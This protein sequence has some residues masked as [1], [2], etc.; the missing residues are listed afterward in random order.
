MSGD[1]YLR[2]VTLT[3]VNLPPPGWYPDP[4]GQGGYRWW[5]GYQ[6]TWY[7]SGGPATQYAPGGPATLYAPGGPMGQW[8]PLSP[9]PPAHRIP[10][11]AA[12]WGLAGVVG[13]IVLG[14]ILQGVATAA[15]PGSD[16]AAL[17][18]GEIGL[19]AA[20]AATC[21]LVSRRYGTGRLSD[22][23]GLRFKPGDVPLGLGV[24]VILLFVAGI[25]GAL[26]A[27]TSLHGSNT[28]FLTGQRGNTTGVVVVTLVAAVGAP[29]FEELF[30]RGFLRI[31]LAA[32][33][34]TGA[35]WVQA[36][37]FG[38]AHY[39]LTLGWQSISVIVA[40]GAL[41]VVLGFLAQRTG[42]LAPGMIAHGTFNLMVALAIVFG[43][44]SILGWVR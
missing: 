3:P 17:L 38:L 6:W 1:G 44:A 26:F 27:H 7:V 42:R 43:P 40:I 36:L 33:L 30:F 5:D 35:V 41:G 23:F 4:G 31:S 14:G 12:W 13:G 32:R 24:S 9:A 11:R 20:L 10:A 37:L 2:L 25:I 29:V 39:Q 15:F 34:G 21:I 28:Q 8:T 16:A 19:W 22:D 18:F